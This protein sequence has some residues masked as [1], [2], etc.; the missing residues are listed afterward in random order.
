LHGTPTLAGTTSMNVSVSDAA[1]NFVNKNLS[2]TVSPPPCVITPT[3][4]PA[5]TNGQAYSAQLTALP[6]N[7]CNS[8]D[9]VSYSRW[10]LIGGT[11]PPDF[12]LQN[13]TGSNTVSIVNSNPQDTPGTYTFMIEF[14]G[15]APTMPPSGQ[16]ATATI[17]LVINP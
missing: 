14:F 1:S 5:A 13:A 8:T 4:L 9:P 3:T 12:L 16:N 11:I 6:A 7:V 17:T 10:Q 15:A 2:L